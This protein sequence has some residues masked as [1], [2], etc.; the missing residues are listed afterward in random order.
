MDVEELM[1]A[2]AGDAIGARMARI[3]SAGAGIRGRTVCFEGGAA[4]ASIGTMEGSG[5]EESPIGTN[6]LPGRGAI[7][8]GGAG[9][10]RLCGAWI[11]SECASTGA[12]APASIFG[13]AS[14]DFAAGAGEDVV[15]T[16]AP[17]GRRHQLHRSLVVLSIP[18]HLHNIV[19]FSR[20]TSQT[21][22][23][24]HSLT[25][26]RLHSTRRAWNPGMELYGPASLAL[27]VVES[28]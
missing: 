9:S 1:G 25:S 19:S 5:S 14:P 28:S 17:N 10:C 24:C 4:V 12:A 26:M 16:L 21:A 27:C 7:A 8:T 6:S 20:K 2:G 22:V 23:F 13:N 18:H 11:P 15:P 3:G